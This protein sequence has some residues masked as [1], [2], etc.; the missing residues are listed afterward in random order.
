MPHSPMYP[1]LQDM[2][3]AISM[4]QYGAPISL[5]TWP[6]YHSFQIDIVLLLSTRAVNGTEKE[7]PEKEGA[8]NQEKALIDTL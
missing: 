5:I 7:C 4:S 8:F 1:L 2:K 3:L 6:Q